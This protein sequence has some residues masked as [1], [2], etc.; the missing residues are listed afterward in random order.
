MIEIHS[1]HKYVQSTGILEQIGSYFAGLA[2]Q[3][4]V[5]NCHNRRIGSCQ[6]VQSDF[7]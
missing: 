7:R 2:T 1:S 6:L 4:L 3:V 5:I